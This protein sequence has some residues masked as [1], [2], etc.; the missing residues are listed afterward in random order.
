MVPSLYGI[1]LD[2]N[3]FFGR[4]KKWLKSKLPG[5]SQNDVETQ[6]P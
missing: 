4:V 1:G 5:G 2:V 6:I 3:D